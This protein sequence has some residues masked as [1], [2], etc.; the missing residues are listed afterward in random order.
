VGS[1]LRA[2]SCVGN[3][4]GSRH[5]RLDRPAVEIL[6]HLLRILPD[7]T[8][9]PERRLIE[10]ALIESGRA[11][12]S[13]DLPPKSPAD[14]QARNLAFVS[15]L[16]VA[17]MTA[18]VLIHSCSAMVGNGAI[19]FSGTWW[20]ATAID[21]GCSWAVPAFIM[22]S[23]ALLLPDRPGETARAFYARRLHRIAI[24]LI[25]AHVGYLFFRWWVLGEQL[26]LNGVV[27]DLL[28][29]RIYV[30]LYF[31][32]IIL[33]LY[34]ITPLLRSALAGRSRRALLVIGGAWIAWM[35]AV[36]SGASVLRLVGSPAD[37]WQPAALVLFI[38]YVGY[39]VLG[40]ALRDT[41]LRGGALLGAIGLFLVADAV[42]VWQY[43]VG[44]SNPVLLTLAGGG[45]QGL[46][47]AASTIL[48]FVIARSLFQPAS[49]AAGPPFQ[50]VMRHL[51]ELSLGVFIVHL[52]PLQLA[53]NSALFT[54][55]VVDRSL[56]LTLAL[57]LLV[58]V[59]SF[60]ACAVIARI[61][62]LRK[63]IGF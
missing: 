53:W 22:V 8:D 50:G 37:I 47:V 20:A 21:L 10:S 55:G 41:V 40:Y 58:T 43:A 25:V 28:R 39:F 19:R 14:D 38:P 13:A 32:W 57:W 1:T 26:T 5:A 48:V 62:V 45:Y 29:A 33:G 24:P 49:R 11:M 2:L 34:L 18:V 54:F 60:A 35:W 46:P 9:G 27:R 17:A 16:R 63:T 44:A 42:V 3:E 52:V 12:S 7:T 15:Y 30:Q 61:P 59:I 36:W 31:F 6:R 4:T 56:P 23:G 51:G